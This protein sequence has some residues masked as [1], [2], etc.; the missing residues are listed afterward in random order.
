[1][2]LPRPRLRFT[3]RRLM[4]AVA[5][6]G[7]VLGYWLTRERWAIF[8]GRADYHARLG[9]FYRASI[10]DPSG[11]IKLHPEIDAHDP[12]PPPISPHAPQAWEP[13][14]CRL[15]AEYH[16]RMRRHWKSRW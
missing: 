9:E 1:M 8:R 5:I 15:L 3:V 16:A 12:E 13:E 2:R 6:I 4:V 7:V 11:W 10:D 14:N